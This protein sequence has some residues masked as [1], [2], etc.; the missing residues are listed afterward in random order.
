LRVVRLQL[1]RA[2]LHHP[3]PRLQRRTRSDEPLAYSIYVY[4]F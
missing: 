1:P 4:S 2:F 3:H